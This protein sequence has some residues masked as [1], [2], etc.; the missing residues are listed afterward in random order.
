MFRASQMKNAID[1][2]KIVLWFIIIIRAGFLA[3][4]VWFGVNEYKKWKKKNK[5]TDAWIGQPH[6]DAPTEYLTPDT[7]LL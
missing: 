1:I 4:V 2:D 7:Y 3:A 5:D 6:R